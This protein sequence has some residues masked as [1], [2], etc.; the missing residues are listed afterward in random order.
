MLQAKVELLEQKLRKLEAEPGPSMLRPFHSRKS[1]KTTSTVTSQQSP[2]D[3]IGHIHFDE[4]SA[5]SSTMSLEH[6]GLR[7]SIELFESSEPPT[8]DAFVIPAFHFLH[9]LSTNESP[10][11][12]RITLTDHSN[13]G[14]SEGTIR[15]SINTPSTSNNTSSSQQSNQVL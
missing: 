8:L 4:L 3:I 9:P 14:S 2:V 6:A 7:N 15:Y 13:M 12:P 5:T 10:L 1:S 11:L